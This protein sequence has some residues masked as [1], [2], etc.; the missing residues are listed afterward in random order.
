MCFDISHAPII[1][2]Q[3]AQFQCQMIAHS[4]LRQEHAAL[5]MQVSSSL[6]SGTNLKGQSRHHHNFTYLQGKFVLYNDA[7]RAH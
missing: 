7:S 1:P 4:V 3:M 5:T 2:E 6:R